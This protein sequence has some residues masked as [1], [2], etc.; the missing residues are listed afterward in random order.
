M[1]FSKKLVSAI[2]L[3]SGAMAL[4]SELYDLSIEQLLNIDVS[5]AS[6][7]KV[8]LA[9][10][11]GV[12]SVYT[13][14]DIENLGYYTIRDLASITPGFS[15]ASIYAGQNNL[16]VRGQ[17][18]EGFDN[19]KVL[20]LLDG[21]PLNHLRNGRAPIDTDMSLI[22]VEKIE[23]LKGPGSALYGTGAFFGV[24]NITTLKKGKGS[25]S[26]AQ[27]FGGSH[28]SHGAM[29]F[30]AFG[31]DEIEGRVRF[32]QYSQDPTGEIYGYKSGTQ[33]YEHSK[34]RTNHG[35]DTVADSHSDALI[36][37]KKGALKNLSIGYI[38]NKNEHGTFENS[39]DYNAYT[40]E[41]VTSSFYGKY[42]KEINEKLSID[43]YLRYSESIEEGN[44]YSYNFVFKGYD[45][46]VEAKYDL[47]EKMNFVFGTSFDYRFLADNSSGTKQGNGQG[48]NAFVERGSGPLRT[49]AGYGQLSGSLNLGKGL[50]YTVG[51][52]FDEVNS[53]YAEAS[54]LSP[55]ISLIQK[56]SDRWNAKLLFSSALRSPD[57]KSTL[58]NAGVVEEGNSL[59]QSKL[60]AETANSYEF[61]MT[62][63]AATY[64]SSLSL[65]H[66][67]I[68]DALNRRTFDTK[69]SY[70]NDSGETVSQGAEFEFKYFPVKKWHIFFNG[71]YAKARLDKLSQESDISGQDVAGA[72][73][74]M[75]NIGTHYQ[76]NKLQL[77]LVGK[78]LDEFRSDDQDQRDNGYFLMDLNTRYN[79]TDNLFLSFKVLNLVKRDVRVPSFQEQYYPQTIHLGAGYR[80]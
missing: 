77:T 76:F 48:S 21:I 19:N 2:I 10:A 57:L 80:F 20:V 52:R 73:R 11:P 12:I 4:E 68:K 31:N 18:V 64:S 24:I 51:L 7:Q 15:S 26:E 59:K 42:Q 79:Y 25:H 17:R 61:G 72:P 75:A 54:K 14:R 69:N 13:K 23:F 34:T 16:M 3:S 27:F 56:L 30:S 39:S 55:R 41:F 49:Y 1:E 63:T 74:V 78:Y 5:V 43:S 35:F 50:L 33:S 38:Q 29:G 6:K 32:A 40:Y 44:R 70:R 60:N 67:I 46:Q 58:I 45:G 22:G 8:S 28:S 71:S 9:D 65:F 36:K 47:N 62:Y 66:T 37:I 53:D